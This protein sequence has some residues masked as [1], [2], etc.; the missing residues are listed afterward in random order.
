MGTQ[1]IYNDT[2][3]TGNL[4]AQGSIY[5]N[6]IIVSDPSLESS[7]VGLSAIDNIVRLS[8]ATYDAL[9]T[10]RPSTLYIIV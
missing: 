3:I 10:K 2:I 7:S 4:N 8:Q 6:R 9:A 5:G 1:T